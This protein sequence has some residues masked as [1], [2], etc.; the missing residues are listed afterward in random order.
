MTVSDNGSAVEITALGDRARARDFD[1]ISS[2]IAERIREL[3]PGDRRRSAYAQ[4]LAAH[5]RNQERRAA[6]LRHP[7]LAA[8][9]TRP[10]LEYARPGHWTGY[11]PPRIAIDDDG[12]LLR[13]VDR[14]GHAVFNQFG[15]RSCGMVYN[16][17]DQRQALVEISTEAYEREHVPF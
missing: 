1:T 17:S 15:R 3:P 5:A 6:V 7:D 9:L 12:G 14:E 8:R 4:I 10:P 11:I 13:R 16:N 2:L